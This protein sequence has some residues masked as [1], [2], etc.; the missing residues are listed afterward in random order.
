ML[1][2][3][4]KTVIARC[5][6]CLLTGGVEEVVVVV[7]PGG[8]GVAAAAS[9]YPVR[10]VRSTDSDGDMATSLRAGRDALTAETSG[11]LI[12]LC[13]YPLVA[14]ETVARL[15]AAHGS[16]QD[17]IWIPL[18]IGRR[19][20]P[21]LVPRSLLDKL[22]EPLTLRDLVRGNPDRVRQAAVAD[23]GVLRDMDTPED[24]QMMVEYCRQRALHSAR[25][26]AEDALH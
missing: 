11:V 5:L 1:P 14:P 19:G 17:A 13:D 4:G 6:E 25:G 7:A 18:H 20:H 15:V 16:E 26:G 2:L 10:V 9:G 24:Y 12:A 8:N 23:P 22:V 3:D 21:I